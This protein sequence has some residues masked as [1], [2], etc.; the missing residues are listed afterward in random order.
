MFIWKIHPER[1]IYINQRGVQLFLIF[2]SPSVHNVIS[3]ASHSQQ[4]GSAW[5]T[6]SATTTG[7]ILSHQNGPNQKRATNGNGQDIK[8][9]FRYFIF[10]IR[11]PCAPYYCNLLCM[12]STTGHKL[13]GATCFR[14]ND[15]PPQISIPQQHVD[16]MDLDGNLTGISLLLVGSRSRARDRVFY[17]HRLKSTLNYDATQFALYKRWGSKSI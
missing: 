3:I 13:R 16:V 9:R 15:F 10:S 8:I 1:G 2:T 7:W 5:I 11:W 12:F 14:F 4:E 6:I 17:G